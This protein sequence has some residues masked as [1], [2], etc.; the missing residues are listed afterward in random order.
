MRKGSTAAT[1]KILLSAE[2]IQGPTLPNIHTL[3]GTKF[4]D[5]VQWYRSIDRLRAFGAENRVPSHGQPVYGPEK[6]EEVLRMTRDGVQFV[7]DQTIRHM[8]KGLTPDELAEAVWRLDEHYAELR[9]AARERLGSLYDPQ[10]Y[11]DSL[12]GMFE[13]SWDFPSVE[14]PPPHMNKKFPL[15]LVIKNS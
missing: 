11:P 8:N 2:V 15:P 12:D 10:D 4:R 14:P 3:R 1:E 13:V 7:H 6:V 9:S 5:P